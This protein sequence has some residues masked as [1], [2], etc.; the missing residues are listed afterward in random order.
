MMEQDS[1]DF[2]TE[3]QEQC[4]EDSD[5]IAPALSYDYDDESASFELDSYDP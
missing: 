3:L 5:S 4:E 1:F 2:Y